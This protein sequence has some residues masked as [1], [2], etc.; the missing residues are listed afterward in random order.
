MYLLLFFVIVFFDVE[1]KY[2]VGLHNVVKVSQDQYDSC[3]YTGG[4]VFNSGDD[5]ITLEK[6]TSYFICIIG[7]HCSNGVKAAITAN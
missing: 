1:F 4:Q 5:K 7:P 2:K 6:G 3:K